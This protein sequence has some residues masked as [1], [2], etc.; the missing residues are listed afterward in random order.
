[1]AAGDKEIMLASEKVQRDNILTVVQFSQETR[2]L[3]RVLEQEV[4]RLGN[5]VRSYQALVEQ[6]K[7]QLAAL[8]QKF[9]AAGSVSL[10]G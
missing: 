1:M 6:Q 9:Y 10:N 2:D 5:T 4:I 7:K 8:Q 3:A